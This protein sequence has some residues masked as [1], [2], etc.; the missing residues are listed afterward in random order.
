MLRELFGRVVAI[1]NHVGRFARLPGG[2]RCQDGSPEDSKKNQRKDLTRSVHGPE[3]R[4]VVARAAA[5]PTWPLR[6]LPATETRLDA[7][8]DQATFSGRIIGLKASPER[9]RDPCCRTRPQPRGS[10]RA[11]R[12]VPR[13]LTDTYFATHRG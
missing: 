7:S 1:T 4:R 3:T 5:G 13:R 2:C 12:L 9:E 6:Q 8:K 11:S 10:G